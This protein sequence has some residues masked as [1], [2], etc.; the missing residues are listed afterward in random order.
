MGDGAGLAPAP[1][2]VPS[3]GDGVGD[4]PA[5]SLGEED[6]EGGGCFV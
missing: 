3:S 1:D 2:P 4:D 5:A 6:A